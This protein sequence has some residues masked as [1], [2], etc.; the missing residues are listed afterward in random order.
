MGMSSDRRVTRTIEI[1]S[2]RYADP[3]LR[4]TEI[5]ASFNLSTSRLRHLF[6]VETGFSPS[7][8]LKRFR[9][10]MAKRLAERSY[11]RVKEIASNV[12]YSD[13]SHFVR[14]FKSFHGKTPSETRR[15]YWS[16]ADSDLIE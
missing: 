15:I 5:A 7:V 3:R 11:L 16:A 6:T 4:L 2:D 8:Y 14:D 10:S 1:L 9:L 13:V 12:G